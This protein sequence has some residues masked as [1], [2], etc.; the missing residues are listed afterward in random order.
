MGF[1]STHS[2]TLYNSERTIY[3]LY[4]TYLPCNE[5]QQWWDT[6]KVSN[7]LVLHHIMY[8]L[9]P[10]ASTS[11]SGF[12]TCI[13]SAGP[14]ITYNNTIK[15]RT[16]LQ[17]Y[18]RY[19]DFAKSCQCLLHGYFLNHRYFLMHGILPEYFSQICECKQGD[20]SIPAYSSHIICSLTIRRFSACRIFYC[21]NLEPTTNNTFLIHG[22]S[23]CQ[24]GPESAQDPI[25]NNF[26]TIITSL[27]KF[28]RYW[29]IP[30][31]KE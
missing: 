7:Y 27:S 15:T 29:I 9:E 28:S 11:P 5:I 4:R 2:A 14:G 3:K 26:L 31:S 25:G 24:I 13:F 18:L 30:H 17:S 16:R 1:N 23:T 12:N 10:Y 6:S 19:G 8:V 21:Q 22:T 20:S